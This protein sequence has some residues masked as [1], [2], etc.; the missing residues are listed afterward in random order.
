MKC[1]GCSQCS[2]KISC[3][4][5]DVRVVRVVILLLVALMMVVMILKY[6]IPERIS[7]PQGVLRRLENDTCH[8]NLFLGKR[9]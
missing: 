3:P 1:L 7:E 5:D 2:V 6:G 9:K 4:G 8:F